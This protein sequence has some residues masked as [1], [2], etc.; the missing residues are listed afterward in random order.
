MPAATATLYSYGYR[1]T[2]DTGAVT[3]TDKNVFVKKFLFYGTTIDDAATIQDLKG[4][5]QIKLPSPVAKTLNVFDV[6]DKDGARFEGLVVSALTAST[7]ILYIF[8]R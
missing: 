3:V 2:G 1:V 7:D 6:G 4:N 5:E 8:I